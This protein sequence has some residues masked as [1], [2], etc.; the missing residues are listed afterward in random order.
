M[1]DFL[2]RKAQERFVNGN[3]RFLILDIAYLRV[4]PVRARDASTVSLGHDRRPLTTAVER[5]APLREFGVSSML[6]LI[7]HACSRAVFTRS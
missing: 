7:P 1:V 2:V 3:E 4:V 5:S 6:D